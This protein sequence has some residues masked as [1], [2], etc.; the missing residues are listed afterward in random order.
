M[1]GVLHLACETASLLPVYRKLGAVQGPH[2]SLAFAPWRREARLDQ[3]TLGK[4]V[5]IRWLWLQKIASGHMFGTLVGFVCMWIS[6]CAMFCSV[7]VEGSSRLSLEN[8]AGRGRGSQQ[9]ACFRFRIGM[10]A[11]CKDCVFH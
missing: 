3:S 7:R 10:R 6:M 1:S 8:E 11:L 5:A 2:N 4:A 9:R